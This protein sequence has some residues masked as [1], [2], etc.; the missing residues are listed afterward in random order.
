MARAVTGRRA[1]Q[2]DEEWA[3]EVE[4][5]LTA[6]ETGGSPVRV[7]NWVLNDV[8]GDL[9]AT[10]AAGRRIILTPPDTATGPSVNPATLEVAG[11]KIRVKQSDGYLEAVSP[12]GTETPF[13][14]P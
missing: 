13:A 11:W 9:V 3:R 7:G 14:A 2:T 4:H 5:R 6:L 1:P 10:N 8:A 12:N